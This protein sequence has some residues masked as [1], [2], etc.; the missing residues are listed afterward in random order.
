M[1]EKKEKYRLRCYD[2]EHTF[3]KELTVKD[4]I[5]KENCPS[6]GKILLSWIYKSVL[7][8]PEV[9]QYDILPPFLTDY[10]NRKGLIKPLLERVI[11]F[12]VILEKG[13]E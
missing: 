6:C 11:L 13:Y 3:E 10:T 4:S 9:N 5:W 1:G 2:C 7:F 8:Q 12:G